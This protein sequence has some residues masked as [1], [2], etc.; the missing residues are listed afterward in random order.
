MAFKVVHYYII[1]RTRLVKTG[2]VIFVFGLYV[3]NYDAT[4]E[5]EK[6]ACGCAEQEVV[7]CR[8]SFGSL[9]THT[10]PFNSP[11]SIRDTFTLEVPRWLYDYF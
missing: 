7:H 2:F 4:L 6:P 11:L 8:L 1:K 3:E 9:N 10:Q 5:S